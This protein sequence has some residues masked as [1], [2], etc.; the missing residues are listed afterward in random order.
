VLFG[1]VVCLATAR[2]QTAPLLSHLVSVRVDSGPVENTGD[3]V[4][5][6]FATT[7]EIPEALWLRLT[8]DAVQLAGRSADANASYLRI[9]GLLDG[10][11]QQLDARHLH[12]WHN[13]SAYFNGNWVLIELIA[14]PGTGPNRL[15]MSS[16]IAGERGY[17][18]DRSICGPTDDR[19]LSSDPR[20]GR[21]QPGG[22]SAFI[23]DDCAHCFYSAAPCLTANG[24]VEFNVPLSNADGSVNH[25][26]PEDQYALD[27]D[28]AQTS[29]ATDPG[30]NWAYFGC[31]PNTNTGLTPYEAQGAFI[32][33]ANA[34]P[35]VG[36]QVSLTGYGTV[37]SP[38]PLAWNQVQ[39][40]SVGPLVTSSGTL[41][42]YDADTT[43]GT[44]GAPVIWEQTGQAVG[45]HAAGGCT[46]T[47][48]EN[49]GTGTN[50]AGLITARNYPTGVCTCVTGMTV[51]PFGGFESGGEPGGPFDP[52][53]CD[54]LLLNVGSTPFEYQVAKTSAW[55]TLTNA[56]G[57]L[58]GGEW[59]TVTVALN[60]AAN[61]L[62]PGLYADLLSF[63]NTTTHQGDTTRTVT[64]HVGNPVL[65]SGWNLD[66]D[67]G[68][69]ITGGEWA[70]GRP[71]GGGGTSHGSHDPSQGATGLNVY[72]VNL[73]GDYTTEPGG[74]YS[75]RLGPV[76]LSE[77]VA[78]ISLR[79]CRWLN[80]DYQPYVSA[81][82]ALSTD[83]QNW[84][85][86]WDNGTTEIVENAWSWQQYDVTA[87]AA[88]Q[89]AV[90]IQ[91]S[92]Q[93]GTGAWAYSGWNLDDI[94]I[95]A[96]LRNP[97]RPGDLTCD[98]FID[99]GDISAFLLALSSQSGYEIQFPY[100]RWLNADC[101][102]DGLVDFDDINPFVILLSG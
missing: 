6:V 89:P 70:F 46:P 18:S 35:P 82:I 41:L 29:G 14:Y 87:L 97:P 4:A 40:A 5:V 99:F 25:P 23:V 48:G 55:L 80:T 3:A 57:S 38:A 78:E 52:A 24:I 34:L 17:L 7:L 53:S 36:S 98:G 16:V 45:I 84:A 81:T 94:E 22:C 28:S 60:S 73:S 12:E 101:N 30:R 49:N 61:M 59:T 19:V 71:T 43:G 100:C 77:A 58:A 79:F 51:F 102:G 67:P 83:G 42:Q 62:S 9:T 69:T 85:S 92:Y 13:T 37:T 2:A 33:V 75:L 68:W 66:T 8:F 47:G 44:A 31:Y 50:H 21:L 93:V 32:L 88:R 96:V 10:A 74:P 76:D 39:K 72:G 95:W 86:V 56:T 27:W 63:Q 65:I 11:A 90:Y 15:V 26:P 91:W 64:L 20:I 54:Y 1:L